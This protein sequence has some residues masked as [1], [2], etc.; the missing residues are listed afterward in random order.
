M[1]SFD[2][3]FITNYVLN[4]KQ[5]VKVIDIILINPV[6][7]YIYI[8]ATENWRMGTRGTAKKGKTQ[9][10]MYKWSKT[11]HEKLWTDGRGY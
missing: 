10:K 6:C 2:N 3:I 4:L 8:S 1:L 7:I 11:E 5:N 9:R